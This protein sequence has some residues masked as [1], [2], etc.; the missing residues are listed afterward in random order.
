M[1]K[2]LSMI[3]HEALEEGDIVHVDEQGIWDREKRAP[4]SEWHFHLGIY[5]AYREAGAIVH[6]HSRFASVLACAHKP[7]PAFHYMVAVAGGKQIPLASYALFG[8]W[9]ISRAW[10]PAC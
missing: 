3:C 1:A 9:T 6:C 10:A 8:T 4:S 5:R 7:I 2:H